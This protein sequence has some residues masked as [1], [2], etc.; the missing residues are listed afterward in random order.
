MF[1]GRKKKAAAKGADE[2]TVEGGETTAI[3]VAEVPAEPLPV[4][5]TNEV[6]T[7]AVPSREEPPFV[8]T[9]SYTPTADELARAEQTQGR[10]QFRSW[11]VDAEQGYSLLT[12]QQHGKFVLVFDKKPSEEV[13]GLMKDAGYQYQADYFGQKNAWIRRN[14][15][16]GHV[17]TEELVQQLSPGRG[18]SPDF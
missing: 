2:T 11:V 9:G 13:R 18:A 12:D 1:K 16:E 10:G 15:F 7:S 8:P 14:D 3:A 6:T 5:N 17:R 4:T